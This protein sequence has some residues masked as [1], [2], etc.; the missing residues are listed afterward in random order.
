MQNLKMSFVSLKLQHI[1]KKVCKEKGNKI[2]S[3]YYS[4]VPFK[5]TILNI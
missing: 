1:K 2:I 4:I 5:I 3:H